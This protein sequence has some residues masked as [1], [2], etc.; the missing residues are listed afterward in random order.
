MERSKRTG[1]EKN[2]IV[3]SVTT[4]MPNKLLHIAYTGLSNWDFA[5]MLNIPD[6]VEITKRELSSWT[7]GVFHFK[8]PKETD[9]RR[10]MTNLGNVIRNGSTPVASASAIATDTKNGKTRFDNESLTSSCWV[11]CKI[12]PKAMLGT[13]GKIEKAQ[14]EIIALNDTINAT[15]GTVDHPTNWLE[16]SN[17]GNLPSVAVALS[18]ENNRLVRK[19]ST[20]IKINTIQLRNG[21]MDYPQGLIKLEDIAPAL[22]EAGKILHDGFEKRQ[23]MREEMEIKKI[24]EQDAPSP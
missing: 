12:I 20:D 7:E 9:Y 16:F 5:R 3:G 13:P 10:M 21:R 6:P 1:K 19:F 2:M 11:D 24:W 18:D 17:D 23:Q 22:R 4:T 14:M 8:C 15:I